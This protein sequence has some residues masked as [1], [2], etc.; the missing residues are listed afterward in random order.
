MASYF[1]VIARSVRFM[2]A[3]DRSQ[4]CPMS[5]I[6]EKRAQCKELKV[7]PSCRQAVTCKK[8]QASP[9]PAGAK[10]KASPRPAAAGEGAGEAARTP[11]A[12]GPKPAEAVRRT[13]DDEDDGEARQADGRHD[14]RRHPPVPVLRQ[15]TRP[16]G[17][18]DLPELRVQQPS[19]GCR[20]SRRR[21]TP[22]RRA[23]GSCTCSRASSPC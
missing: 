3:P 4:A 15:G 7:P 23:T 6:G 16:A 8:C 11:P 12:R 5:T 13:T 17:R 18:R 2:P 9:P 19:P 1:L 10:A 22:R 14:G 20:P 21:S